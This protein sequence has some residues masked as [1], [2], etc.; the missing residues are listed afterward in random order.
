MEVA[1]GLLGTTKG[2]AVVGYTFVTPD[3]TSH[4]LRLAEGPKLGRKGS[5][6]A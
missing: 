5:K 2:D 1:F 6:A 4:A 3:G